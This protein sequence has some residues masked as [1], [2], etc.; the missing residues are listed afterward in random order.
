MSATS[1]HTIL[2]RAVQEPEY[3]GLLLR[4]PDQALTGYELSAAET[5]MF[6]QLTPETF[7]A[8][9]AELETRTSQAVVAMG[10]GGKAPS[11][12]IFTV[13]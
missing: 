11:G 3:R 13:G 9:A 6:K 2:T 4:D 5:A 12:T 7:E 8:A 10:G 1:V